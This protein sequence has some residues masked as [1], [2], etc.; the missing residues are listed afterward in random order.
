VISIGGSSRHWQII[1]A[2]ADHQGIGRPRSCDQHRQIIKALANLIH[3]ISIGRSS[4]H[5]QM[6]FM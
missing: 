3:T 1:N 2:S 5:R 4:R 6:S